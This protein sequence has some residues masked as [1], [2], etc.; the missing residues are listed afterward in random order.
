[1]SN[2]IPEKNERAPIEELK[3]WV[4]AFKWNSWKRKS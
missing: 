2:A 3:A 1:M 4:K